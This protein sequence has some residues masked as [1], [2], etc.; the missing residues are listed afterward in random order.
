MPEEEGSIV[1]V[2]ELSIGTLAAVASVLREAVSDPSLGGKAT[3]PPSSKRSLDKLKL[4]VLP[5][6]LS[7]SDDCGSVAEDC[8]ASECCTSMPSASP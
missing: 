6:F 8:D 4:L 2:L 7:S 3:I 1:I 5:S